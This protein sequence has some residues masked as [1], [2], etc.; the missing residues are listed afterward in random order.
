MSNKE[1]VN[2][3]DLPTKIISR[4]MMNSTEILENSEEAKL[5]Y[6]LELYEKYII[7]DTMENFPSLRKAAKA[8]GVHP[9]TLS[10]KLKKYNIEVKL[11]EE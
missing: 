5:T 4:Q 10:R 7:K 6:L 9:S 3:E 2:I 11:E 8:L 1:E